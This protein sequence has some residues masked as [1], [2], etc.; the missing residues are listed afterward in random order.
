[1]SNSTTGKR[2]AG[3]TLS[4]KL[5][6]LYYNI[7][8]RFLAEFDRRFTSNEILLNSLDAFDQESKTF[9]DYKK[10]KD[11]AECYTNHIDGVILASQVMATKSCVASCKADKDSEKTDVLL[12]HKK[13]KE[14][15][16][17]Y[18]EILK[19]LQILL[20]LP[21][22]TASNERFFSVLKRVKTYI[23]STCGDDRLCHLM[24]MAVE[25][26]LVKSFDQDELVDDF[27]RLR[28]RR[29]PLFD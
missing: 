23:R 17:A 8:D 3:V 1:L 26:N 24:L 16:A 22:T 21:I 10:I 14:L 5:K 12:L 13:L 9:M 11:F 2:N 6:R 25:P 7:I 29:Y 20:T 15:P 4:E 28:P 27:G 19:V 18:S